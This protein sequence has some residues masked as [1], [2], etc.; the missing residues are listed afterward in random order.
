[1]TDWYFK[2]KIVKDI[3]FFPKDCIGF[4]YKICDKNGKCYIG[5]KSLRSKTNP[6]V[7]FN[8]YTKAKANGEDVKKTKNKKES[9]KGLIVWDYRRKMDTESNWQK[10]QSSN[11]ELKKKKGVT[12]EIIDFAFSKK[13][14]T[15]LEL[16][17][18]FHYKVLE[19]DTFYNDNILGKFF[20]KDVKQTK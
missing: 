4:I 17:W 19:V 12:K 6:K 8:V 7:S 14:L 2:N 1:M 10:Y 15:Y 20:R 18:M 16:K 3:S 9:K 5:C 11:T 13:Q